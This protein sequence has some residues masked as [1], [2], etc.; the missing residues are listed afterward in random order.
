MNLLDWL[1]RRKSKPGEASGDRISE[2]LA[3]HDRFLAG[4]P[5]Q[6]KAWFIDLD[7]EKHYHDLDVHDGKPSEEVNI[8]LHK[9]SGETEKKTYEYDK[10]VDGWLIYYQV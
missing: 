6:R 9:V 5:P 3:N 4:L 2:S 7:G 1:K 8:T 10:E